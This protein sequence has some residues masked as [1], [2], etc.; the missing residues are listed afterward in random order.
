M[1]IRDNNKQT[2]N[3]DE[4]KPVDDSEKRKAYTKNMSENTWNTDKFLRINENEKRVQG[5]NINS[6]TSR[7]NT[8][9]LKK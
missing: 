3:A 7:N 4:N 8:R 2:K 9:L 1:E 5:N 6:K